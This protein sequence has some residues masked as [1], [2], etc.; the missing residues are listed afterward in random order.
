MTTTE[1]PTRPEPSVVQRDEGRHHHF[2]NHLATIKASSADGALSAVEF[3]A[4]RGFGPPLH[5][6]LDEDEIVVVLEGEM[7]FRSGDDEHVGREGACALLPHG[8]PHTFQVLSPTARF[9]SVTASGDGHP[10]FDRMV[11]ALGTPTDEPGLPEPGP[12]DPGE[13]ARICAAHG[14]EVLG[15]PPAPLDDEAAR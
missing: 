9:L 4:P 11:A 13:V 5:R 3:V 10:A 7:V 8:V 14:I 15:P 2:L 6:H 12:I 1:Q